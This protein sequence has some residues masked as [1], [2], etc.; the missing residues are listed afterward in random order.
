MKNSQKGIICAILID[1][2]ISE[3]VSK[4]GIEV[5]Q[6]ITKNNDVYS[7]ENTGTFEFDSFIGNKVLIK[8]DS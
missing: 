1:S 7:I 3:D 4:M 2:G 6:K 5:G 8:I